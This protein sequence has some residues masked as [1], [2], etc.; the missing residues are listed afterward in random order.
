[1]DLALSRL[2]SGECALTGGGSSLVLQ[3][4][5]QPVLRADQL[6]WRRLASQLASA[7][8]P[9]EIAPVITSGPV[10]LDVALE[11]NIADID[12]H[13]DYWE[14]GTR[15]GGS[16]DLTCAGRNAS[17]RS[18]LVSERLRFEKGLPLGFSV[19]AMV[20]KLVATELYL[21][22]GELKFAL[23]EEVWGA[24]V[25]DLAFR[26]AL[27]KTVGSDD[28]AL[29]NTSFD[30]LLAKRFVVA[31]LF[32]LSPFLGLGALLTRASSRTIDLTPNIDAV[33]CREGRDVVC[34]GGGLAAST[35]DLGHDVRFDTLRLW[36]YRGFVGV[37]ARHRM[38][39][40]SGSAHVDLV[41]PRVGPGSDGEKG[42]RQWSVSVAPSVS[43]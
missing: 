35:D 36:R 20:G 16:R 2:S 22:G 37:S 9:T 3:R 17:V 40:L 24:R 15:G 30:L 7:V 42:A 1:M 13:A 41:A 32:T 34:N 12:Q 18:L 5:G 23:L 21:I 4:D 14:R 33:A 11:T 39:A 10:G 6:A 38:V 29:L 31:Q 27:S 43:F 19:G 8:A 26:V 25:P 28:V